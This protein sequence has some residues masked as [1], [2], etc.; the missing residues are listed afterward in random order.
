MQIRDA[1]NTSEAGERTLGKTGNE[2]RAINDEVSRISKS[3]I[4]VV[5]KSCDAVSKVLNELDRG[6]TMARPRS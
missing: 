6:S 4:R 3:L 2:R 1:G 5:I